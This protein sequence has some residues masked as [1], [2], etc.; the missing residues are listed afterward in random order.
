[1]IVSS[2][3]IGE[4]TV[5]TSLKCIDEAK[6]GLFSSEIISDAGAHR[7]AGFSTIA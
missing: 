5:K 1:M 2:T 4:K 7:A 3:S 6:E